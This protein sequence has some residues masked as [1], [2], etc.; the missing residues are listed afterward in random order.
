ME[1]FKTKA[2]WIFIVLCLT[3]IAGVGA[4][5]VQAVETQTILYVD[6][7]RETDP[8]QNR[9]KTITEAVNAAP[10]AANEASRVIIEIADG[11]YRE[12]LRISKPYLT[13]RSASGD[14]TKVV[15]TWYYGIGYVYNNI[16]PDGFYDPNVDWSADSTWERLTRYNIGDSVNSITYYDKNGVLHRNKSVQGGVLGKPDRWGCAVKLERSAIGFIAENITFEASFRAGCGR[17]TGTAGQPQAQPGPSA[18]RE[19]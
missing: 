4:R 14:P 13:L 18:G 17:C 9:Y 15:L 19:H 12:Q 8:A 7:S 10:V 5:A 11:V 1:M 2:R 3:L 16:G 6:G